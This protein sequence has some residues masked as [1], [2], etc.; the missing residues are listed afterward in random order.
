MF[1]AHALQHVVHAPVA[2]ARGNSHAVHFD[3][4]VGSRPSA[5]NGADRRRS[6]SSGLQRLHPRVQHPVR[7]RLPRQHLIRRPVVNLPDALVRPVDQ[8]QRLVVRAAGQHLDASQMSRRVEERELVAHFPHSKFNLFLSR[9]SSRPVANETCKCVQRG[10]AVAIRPPQPRILNLELRKLRRLQSNH[11]LAG[12]KMHVLRH[13]HIVE[14]GRQFAVRRC[15]ARIRQRHFNLHVGL[16]AVRLGQRCNHVQVADLHRPGRRQCHILPDTRIAVANPR[17][18]VPPFGGGKRWSVQQFHSAVLSGPPF[19]RLLVRNP[20][21]R[22]RR[23]PHGQR[24]FAACG[25]VRHVEF[26]AQ[27]RARKSAEFFPIHPDFGGVIHAF[28]GER[29]PAPARR[30]RRLEFHAVPIVLVSQALGN[31]KIV[32]PVIR[33]WINAA[34]DHRGQHRARH[35]RY[36]PVLVGKADLG[37]LFAGGFHLR[38]RLQPPTARELPRI[39]ARQLA[40]QVRRAQLFRNGLL[41]SALAMRQRGWILRRAVPGLRACLHR[42][43]LRSLFIRG[44]VK[45]R[46]RIGHR[47]HLLGRQRSREKSSTPRSCRRNGDLRHLPTATAPSPEPPPRCLVRA[48]SSPPR[49]HRHREP[50]VRHRWPQPPGATS[51]RSAFDRRPQIPPSFVLA[52]ATDPADCPSFR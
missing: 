19:E 17:N 22:R 51:A 11:R 26:P 37:N 15:A 28:K 52:P 1:R 42:P 47:L 34:V 44:L 5:I 40:M 50:H 36:Q 8:R 20:G 33:I 43:M 35:C 48:R 49:D 16:A 24:I 6:F 4:Q 41:Y 12:V 32:Q 27:K 7:Q 10:I 25:N 18:P 31:G 45:V 29:E 3:H 30:G 21:M 46:W 38:R 23:N 13:L 9:S 14:S 39:V 2:A